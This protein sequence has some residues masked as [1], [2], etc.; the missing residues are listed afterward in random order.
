MVTLPSGAKIVAKWFIPKRLD[1][2]IKRKSRAQRAWAAARTLQAVGLPTPKP[3][4][5]LRADGA[6][7]YVAEWRAGGQTARQLIKPHRGRPKMH[8][9]PTAL[10]RDIADELLRLLFDLE[11]HGL[12]HGDTK[13]GNLLL[14]E[15]AEGRRHYFWVDLESLRPCSRTSEHRHMKNLI[16]LNGSIG[17]K[18]SREDRMAFLAAFA[19]RH[20]W[21]LKPKVAADIENMTRR[22]LRREVSGQC[23]S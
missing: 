6:S 15:D 4:G 20:A 3:L 1:R 22:R 21:A 19:E 18:I 14:E 16:Q 23:G 9:A 17:T 5:L 11:D 7:C 8:L 2:Q 10:R 13:A 12:Y